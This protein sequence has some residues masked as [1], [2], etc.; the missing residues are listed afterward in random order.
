MLGP[1]FAK[2]ERLLK[3]AEFAA[4][5]KGGRRY[6]TKNLTL[7]LFKNPLGRRRLGLSV[8]ARVGPSVARSRI[9]RL[10]REFFRLNKEFFPESTDILMTVR[11][12]AAFLSYADVDAELKRL[13]LVARAAGRE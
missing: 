10:L 9:K 5:K 2:N 12:G 3:P 13:R 8:S 6:S 11:P 7:Y 1:A 4:V